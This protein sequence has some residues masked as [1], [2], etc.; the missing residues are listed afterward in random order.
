MSY[1]KHNE[2]TEERTVYDE[3]CVCDLCGCDIDEYEDSLTDS[4]V[5]DAK[6]RANVEPIR[7]ELWPEGWWPKG[8]EDHARYHLCGPCWREK[9]RPLLNRL[10]SEEAEG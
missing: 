9:V 7:G 2:R 1:E 10:T 8:D 4:H 5:A 6:D 3:R